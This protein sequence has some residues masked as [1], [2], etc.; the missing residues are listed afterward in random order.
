[1]F[2]IIFWIEFLYNIIHI[3]CLIVGIQRPCYRNAAPKNSLNYRNLKL[4]HIMMQ[5]WI[6]SYCTFYGQ[7]KGALI[8]FQNAQSSVSF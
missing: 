8:I 3:I 6:F 1:M 2:P 4:L 7:R 5:L